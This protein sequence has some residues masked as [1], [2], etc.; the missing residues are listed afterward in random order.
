MKIGKTLRVRDRKEWRSWLA[1]NHKSAADIWL[2]F[3]HKASGKA[4]VAYNDV[5]EEALCFGWIDSIV[6]NLDHESHAQ[7]FSPRRAGSVLSELN[8]ERVKK[9][10]AQ[11]KMTKAGL[12]A[13]A[14]AFAPAEY[15]TEDFALA[16]DI[17]AALKKAPAAWANF[18][19]FP[20]GYRRIR[21]G[22]IESQRKHGPAALKRS[23]LHFVKRTALNKRIGI[24]RDSF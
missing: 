3:F 21:I 13:I 23:L 4:G 19:K 5:V 11:K 2:V 10:I 22:Y 24:A 15:K 8:K 17:I 14:H 7:R 9:L 20:A 16:P 1:A 18:R 6:K 12:A